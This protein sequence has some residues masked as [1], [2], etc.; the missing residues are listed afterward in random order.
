VTA[1][2]AVAAALLAGGLAGRLAPAE[3]LPSAGAPP[4]GERAAAPDPRPTDEARRALAGG[5]PAAA[6]SLLETFIASRPEEAT[7]E[8]RLLLAVALARAGEP[9]AALEE[10][11]PG[12][13]AGEDLTPLELHARGVAR[14]DLARAQMAAEGG[15][16]ELPL[17]PW[18]S[19]WRYFKGTR[20]PPAPW[21]GAGFDDSAWLEGE[22]SIGFGD[23][24]DRTVIADMM[25]RYPSLHLR[26]SFRLSSS[27]G[28]LRERLLLRVYYDDGF[29]AYL[30]GKEIARANLP[31]APGTDVPWNGLAVTSFEPASLAEFEVATDAIEDGVNTLAIQAHQASLSSS[32]LSIDAE[33]TLFER[34]PEKEPG[35]GVR[36][37]AQA[38]ADLS[39]ALGGGG[40]PPGDIDG[41]SLDLADALLLGGRTEEA[42]RALEPLLGSVV[43]RPPGE[44]RGDRFARDLLYRS[45]LEAHG[46][47]EAER[48]ARL[49]S[50]LLPFREEGDGD[51]L[52]REAHAAYLLGRSHHR[53][54][55]RAEALAFYE[56]SRDLCARLDA[57]G[58]TS[59]RAELFAALALLELGRL[60]EAREALTAFASSRG[61]HALGPSA[62]LFLGMLLIGEGAHEAAQRRLAALGARI[63]DRDLKARAQLWAARADFAQAEARALSRERGALEL[64]ARGLQSLELALSHDPRADIALEVKR[65]IAAALLRA[66][67]NEE[68]VLRYEELERLGGGSLDGSYGL[69]VALQLGERLAESAEL[70]R[71]LQSV[72]PGSAYEA[73][74]HFRIGECE[75]LQGLSAGGEEPD[76]ARLEAALTSYAESLRSR[77]WLPHRDAARWRLGACAALLGRPE[78]AARAFAEAA[79]SGSAA[80]AAVAAYLAA[81]VLAVRVL[82]VQAEGGGGSSSGA[83][84]A[85]RAVDSLE[86]GAR[87]LEEAIREAEGAPW[88]AAATVTLARCHRLRGELLADPRARSEA[89]TRAAVF[90]QEITR[91][92]GGAEGGAEPLHA[93]ALLEE[94]RALHG[95]ALHGKA[96]H[97]K[98]SLEE[99][100]ARLRPLRDL[101]PGSMSEPALRAHLVLAEILADA[102]K[103]EEAERT[104]ARGRARCDERAAGGAAGSAAGSAAGNAAGGAAGSA[105]GG[106]AEPWEREELADLAARMALEQ[107]RVLAKLGKRDAA[108]AAW[109]L[110]AR[111]GA[112][113]PAARLSLLELARLEGDL[114]APLALGEGKAEA[115]TGAGAPAGT[116]EG[117]RRSLDILTAEPPAPSEGLRAEWLL[118][119]GRAASRLDELAR[120]DG[121]GRDGGEGR[122]AAAVRAAGAPARE[123]S[124][125]DLPAHAERALEEA[126]ALLPARDRRATLARHEIAALRARR[127]EIESA[128]RLLGEALAA[129]VSEADDAE[130]LL[131]LGAARAAAGE[132]MEAVAAVFQAA[133]KLRPGTRARLDAAGKGIVRFAARPS[134]LPAEALPRAWPSARALDL[135]AR[136]EVLSA[137]QGLELSVA[138]FRTVETRDPAVDLRRFVLD[139]EPPERPAAPPSFVVG[140]R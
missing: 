68:A 105:A 22:G 25:G 5:D 54:G 110:A 136:R 60:R 86:G 3:S 27:R 15:E 45:G 95:R 6:R 39:L 67:R 118:D 109:S 30:N 4:A 81:R 85:A 111:G 40:L 117:L 108:R 32:D 52:A 13:G 127:G 53:L 101:P 126:L 102:G 78:D 24:D 121:E 62:E 123:W 103:D 38:A 33:L 20:A 65:E 84:A 59:I 11:A 98:R 73:A 37:L 23:D 128:A 140:A 137:L 132:G 87:R 100:A 134:V 139:P 34:L 119:L 2:A 58:E 47:G 80:E 28:T 55:E 50:L 42:R 75:L 135:R 133:E 29:V 14:R 57:G 91:G 19:R 66:G 21:R 46:S 72:H 61:R 114:A 125:D 99:G 113:V 88:L 96:L 69:A 77:A 115:G 63:L 1:V 35:T 89:F 16:R 51:S 48:A 76:R 90:A 82:A 93:E 92:E 44:P 83:L 97:G 41:A 71:K 10:L 74:L 129:S 79:A 36:L 116:A 31:G 107:G 106:A 120:L 17:V 7:R 43:A 131:S 104:L 70:S 9:E 26:R 49:L 94:A 56:K 112:A 18:Q 138:P 8:A 124:A 12:N 122:E 64:M 130:L